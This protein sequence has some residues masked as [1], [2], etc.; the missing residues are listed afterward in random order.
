MTVADL[1]PIQLYCL[2]MLAFCV[3]MA[4]GQLLKMIPEFEP[5]QKFMAYLALFFMVLGPAFYGA[6]TLQL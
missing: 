3:V 5:R 1:V 4:A 2:V 6:W